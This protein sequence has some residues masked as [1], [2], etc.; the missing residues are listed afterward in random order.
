MCFLFRCGRPLES[1]PVS[2]TSICWF[3]P[4][5]FLGDDFPISFYFSCSDARPPARPRQGARRLPS[6]PGAGA[7]FLA[8]PSSSFPSRACASSQP[9]VRPSSQGK[10]AATCTAPGRWGPR[11]SPRPRSGCTC[12]R[13]PATQPRARG[14]PRWTRRWRPRSP[15]HFQPGEAGREGP[16]GASS[17]GGGPGPGDGRGCSVARPGAPRLRLP[18]LC[19][20]G[21]VRPGGRGVRVRLRPACLRASRPSA[22]RP[23][24][25]E[26]A[27]RARPRGRPV[28]AR[29][30]LPA[31]ALRLSGTS[32]SPPRPVGLPRRRGPGRALVAES[33]RDDSASPPACGGDAA[34]RPPFAR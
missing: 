1:C 34:A 7:G 13:P 9:S 14:L 4:C 15:R 18:G 11:P 12:P 33:P 10:A 25:P 24:L 32:R 28:R 31:R 16:R 20:G 27:L 26:R 21:T 3:I 19:V 30:S 2:S 22:H 17:A 5:L 29:T 23:L 8:P 6:S